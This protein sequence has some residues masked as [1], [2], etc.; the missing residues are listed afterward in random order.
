MT[1]QVDLSSFNN[2]WFNRGA[3]VSKRVLWYIT[4]F[5]ILKSYFFPLSFVKVFTLRLFGAKI[6]KN[7]IIRPGVNI[8][9]PWKLKIGNNCWLGEN[10]WIDNLDYVTLEDNVCI[11][12]GAFLFCGN[13]NY[14]LESFDLMIRQI[15]IESGAWLGAKSIVCPG[16]KVG[17]HAILSVGSLADK[18]LDSFCVYKGN[19]AVKC[20]KRVIS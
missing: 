6:G 7:V 18:N 8:K 4:N 15:V 17:S 11:S 20:N 16:I 19:P 5:L 2:S 13:H 9:Y 10:V 14:K 12:Q 1:K 3:S